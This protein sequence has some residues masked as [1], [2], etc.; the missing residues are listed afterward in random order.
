M[1][2]NKVIS[3]TL[4]AWKELTILRAEW[5]KTTIADVVDIILA[6]RKNNKNNSKND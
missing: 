4:P 6:E 2:N 1:S 5:E 3:V